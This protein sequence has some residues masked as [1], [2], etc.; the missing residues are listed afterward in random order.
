[1]LHAWLRAGTPRL[2]HLPAGGQPVEQLQYAA[3]DDLA[4]SRLQR[5][6]HENV[7]TSHGLVESV[8]ISPGGDGPERR[9]VQH[10]FDSLQGFCDH[11]RVSQVAF[12][13]LDPFQRRRGEAGIQSDH[14]SFFSQRSH[15][16]PCKVSVCTGDQDTPHSTVLDPLSSTTLKDLPP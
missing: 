5:A 13:G 3:D 6:G 15:H 7:G 2:G 10:G 16:R 1:M 12:E 11:I 8:E 4:N 14:G 9:Q